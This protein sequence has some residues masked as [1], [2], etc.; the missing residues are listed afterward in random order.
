[1]LRQVAPRITAKASCRSRA[2]RHRSSSPIEISLHVGN[3]VTLHI[4][5]QVVAFIHDSLIENAG[6]D[7]GGSHSAHP[8]PVRLLAPAD[9]MLSAAPAYIPL[10][11]G[12]VMHDRTSQL[13][14]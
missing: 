11:E 4:V 2:W 8:K 13:A 14:Q 6:H 1:M 3:Q 10:D 12:D 5:H 9:T 7:R